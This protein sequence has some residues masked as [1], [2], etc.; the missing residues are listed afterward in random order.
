MLSTGLNTPGAGR[1]S[2]SPLPD[3]GGQGADPGP[4]AV[5]LQG[6][7]TRPGFRRR[8]IGGKAITP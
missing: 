1:G 5:W 4:Q 6:L 3:P 2:A 8:G 7:G